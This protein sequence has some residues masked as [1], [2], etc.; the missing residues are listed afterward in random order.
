MDGAQRG[1]VA[2]QTEVLAYGTGTISLGPIHSHDIDIVDKRRI[3]VVKD[4]DVG[5]PLTIIDTPS[6]I[7]SGVLTSVGDG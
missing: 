4:D 1:G 7:A 2:K 3:A 6:T 5:T